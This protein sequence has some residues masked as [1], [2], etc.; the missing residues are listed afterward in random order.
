MRG[1]AIKFSG[2]CKKINKKY[3]EIKHCLFLFKVISAYWNTFVAPFIKFFKTVSKG[4]QSNSVQPGRHV[5]LNV[6][7]ILKPL[8]FEGSF[9]RRKEKKL[10]GAS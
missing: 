8:S 10:A 3:K 7:N 6:F 4:F 1:L 5:F 2:L 9:Y